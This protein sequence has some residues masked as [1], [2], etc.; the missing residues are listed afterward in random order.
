MLTIFSFLFVLMVLVMAHEMGHLVAAKRLGIRVETFSI[1]FGPKIARIR[2][3]GTDYVIRLVPL[4]GYVQLGQAMASGFFCSDSPH[5]SERP[6]LH[7]IIVALA[8]PF[9]NLVLAVVVLSVVSIIGIDSPVFLS[10]PADVGWVAPGSPSEKAGVRSGDRIVEIDGNEV[11]SWRDISRLIPIYEKNR[12]TVKILRNGRPFLLSLF[13]CSRINS[14][15]APAEKIVVGAVAFRSPA[16]RAGLKTGDVI[17]RAGN[18]PMTA[19]AQF[20][21]KVSAADESLVLLVNRGGKAK[22]VHVTPTVDPNTGNKNIGISQRRE[23]VRISTGLFGGL[24]YGFARTEEIFVDSL[25][26]FRALFAGSLSLKALGGP[27]AIARASGGTARN[28]LLPLLSF[29]AFMSIQ[30]GVFNLL[31]FIPIVD[32]GQVTLFLFETLR[33]RP[34]SVLSLERIA[35]AG[36]AAMGVIILFVTYNDVMKLF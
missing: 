32:G 31:P 22:E 24:N 18:Q 33:Q 14:G 15:L 13:D 23:S 5:Y 35:K 7:K 20:R 25:G 21:E 12:L 10:R 17:S 26:T 8:G 36:W 3:G 28:G 9:A 11:D 27:I 34:L 1:G 2:K 16:E 19:W 29:L 6:P 30:L 4:G